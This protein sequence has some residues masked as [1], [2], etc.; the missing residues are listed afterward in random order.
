MLN[1]KLLLQ[2]HRGRMVEIT[3]IV[4]LIAAKSSGESPVDVTF[5]IGNDSMWTISRYLASMSLV[6]SWA[7][8]KYYGTATG[9]NTTLAAWAVRNKLATARWPAGEA[10]YFNW[11]DPSGRMGPAY[12]TLNPRFN[13]SDRAPKADWMSIDEYLDLCKAT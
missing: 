12:S 1:G 5:D 13:D 6:Y 4:I 2:G 9:Q 7:P 10:S 3:L 11:E 8:D